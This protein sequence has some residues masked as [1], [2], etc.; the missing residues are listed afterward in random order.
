MLVFYSCCESNQRTCAGSHHSVV[1]SMLV[2]HDR[3][4]NNLSLKQTENGWIT[5]DNLIFGI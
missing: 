2:S 4:N 3:T 1:E 5:M